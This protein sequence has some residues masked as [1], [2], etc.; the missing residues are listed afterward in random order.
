MTLS[1]EKIYHEFRDP[2]HAFIR[3]H[4]KERKIID[5]E[6]VQRLRSIQQLALTSL[7]YP[8]ATHTR[9]EHSLGVMHVAGQIF[10][11]ITDRENVQSNVAERLPDIR[12]DIRDEEKRVKWRR[13]V[14]MAGLLHDVGHYPFS[15]AVEKGLKHEIMSLQLIR[16]DPLKELLTA[17]GLD[18]EQVGRVALG[19]DDHDKATQALGEEPADFT[20]WEKILAAII[21]G[22][23]G[24]DRIDYLLR[25]SLHAGVAYG[26]FDHHRLI[27]CIRVLIPGP[28]QGKLLLEPALGLSHGALQAFESM[29]LARHFMFGQVYFHPVRQAYDYHLQAFIAELWPKGLPT[30]PEEHLKV[31]DIEVLA[32]LRKSGS[33][34]SM[35]ILKRKHYKVL[36]EFRA[37]SYVGD[38][39]Q[40]ALEQA[41]EVYGKTNVHLRLNDTKPVKEFPVQLRDRQ[42][43]TSS[44]LSPMLA[45]LPSA[46][47][48]F[49][50]F[51]PDAK[52]KEEG[53]KSK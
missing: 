12:G 37:G 42:V 49:L 39:P 6:P 36:Q 45:T 46:T 17:M 14:R 10:D 51:N 15:H 7:V 40:Q 5:S 48:H 44:G 30:T 47:V 2:V 3:A 11:V 8:G 38:A 23:F 35:R 31:T 19:R 53:E 21:T 32:E 4:S 27:D 50:F 25:D 20:P 29:V 22:D 41:K 34:S 28:N 9:F 13:T 43:V 16:S 33:D 26:R 52:K 24:A 1:P 18:A